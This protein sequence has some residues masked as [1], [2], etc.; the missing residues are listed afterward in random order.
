MLKKMINDCTVQLRLDTVD[1]ILIKSGLATL[2]G[3]NMAFVLTYRGG[4]PEPYI[5]G[6][7]LKGVIR[8]HAERIARTLRSPS[9]CEPFWNEVIRDEIER[10]ADRAATLWC[11]KKF[12]VRKFTWKEQIDGP[13]AY[14]DSCPACRL[15]GSTYFGGRLAVSDAYLV[16]GRRGAKLPRDGVGIDRFTGGASKSAKFDLEVV[17][18]ASFACTINIRNF[19]V[20]Q[21]GWLAYVIQDLKDSM[22]SLGSATTRGLGRVRGE[23]EAVRV[24]YV[25]ATADEVQSANGHGRLRGVGTFVNDPSYGFFRGDEVQLPQGQ[26]FSREPGTLRHECRMSRGEDDAFWRACAQKWD[27]YIAGYTVPAKMTHTQYLPELREKR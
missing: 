13:K 9:A 16:D 21:L 10:K 14:N 25:V 18:D 1:P 2:S 27:D 7:S 15:F 26:S 19:E 12:E 20:W 8:S 3:P 17:T 11:G 4:R 23:V 5:P 22:I 24:G 6:S